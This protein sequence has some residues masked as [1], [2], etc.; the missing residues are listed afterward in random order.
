[1]LALVLAVQ[2]VCSPFGTCAE[3]KLAP[4]DSQ[5]IEKGARKA[6]EDF[7]RVRRDHLPWSDGSS[8]HC[9]EVIKAV[10]FTYGD[11]DDEWKP[12]KEDDEVIAARQNLITKLRESR[13][14]LPAN[15]WINGQLVRYLVD[16]GEDARAREAAASCQPMDSWWCLALTG[17]AAHEAGEFV[18]AESAFDRALGAMHTNQRCAWTDIEILL[19]A[20]G[21]AYRDLDC[22][23][24]DSVARRFW[25]IADPLFLTPGNERRSEHFARHVFIQMEDDAP[26]VS[27]SRF[28]Q[29]AEILAVRYGPIAAWAR[30][31]SHSL[32]VETDPEFIGY[33]REPAEVFEPSWK[34]LSSIESMTPAEMPLRYKGART[35][36]APKYAEHFDTLIY[37]VAVFRSADSATIV[38]AYDFTSDSVPKTAPV[39]AG[40]FL[41]PSD[42]VPLFSQRSD[43]LATGVLTLRTPLKPGLVSLETK[44]VDQPRAGRTRYWLPIEPVAPGTIAMSDLMLLSGI[45][46]LPR[47]LAEAIPLAR[48]GTSVSPG[49]ALG[50]YWEVYGAGTR[51]VPLSVS[52]TLVKEGT[53]W[54]KRAA[55]SLGLAGADKPKVSLNWSDMAQ[56]GE[57]ALTGTI[58]LNLGKNEPGR[59]TLRVEVAG[60][61]GKATAQ[62]EIIIRER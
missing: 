10:C 37:Q 3:R 5:R 50:L 45:D 18:A 33:H 1:M 41:S 11:P 20:P 12:P 42:S 9:D 61:P 30:K 32:T 51:P 55:R 22:V 36:Y 26:L 35:G 48:T 54:F 28:W 44:T 38:G 56:P 14:R 6:Q 60:A 58:A 49:E 47:T 52:V 53:G 8:D 23:A 31:E 24:Q 17:F 57:H 62:R 7:E 27:P 2:I 13:D 19:K 4:S 25:W 29:G 34:A 59:Y 46:S 21:N 43:Q 15:R 39:L 16:A 40:L